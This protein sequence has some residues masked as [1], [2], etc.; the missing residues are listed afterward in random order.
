[1]CFAANAF[2]ND[3]FA[4]CDAPAPKPPLSVVSGG[5]GGGFVPILPLYGPRGPESH[6]SANK[7]RP[8]HQERRR[9]PTEQELRQLA[10]LLGAVL[11]RELM[12]TSARVG[13]AM[14]DP[15]KPTVQA[16]AELASCMEDDED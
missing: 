5:S 16:A 6:T 1:M 3:A 8:P 7:S 9:K 10:E 11:R 4:V 14:D 2:Q 13:V 15:I 12:R